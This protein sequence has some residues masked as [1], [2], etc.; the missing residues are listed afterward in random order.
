MYYTYHSL[1]Y[2]IHGHAVQP[3]SHHAEQNVGTQA[4]LSV[5]RNDG[6]QRATTRKKS[7]SNNTIATQRRV[8][9]EL[10]ST[11]KKES[12]ASSVL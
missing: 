5:V 2:P 10:A 1:A 12:H 6:N 3:S 8:L 4:Q 11:T 9:E 7:A